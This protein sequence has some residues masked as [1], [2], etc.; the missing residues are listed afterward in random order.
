MM[1]LIVKTNGEEDNDINSKD[2]GDITNTHT[3]ILVIIIV[4]DMMV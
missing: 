2:N 4:T 1:I 3:K